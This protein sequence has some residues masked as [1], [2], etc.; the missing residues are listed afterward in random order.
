MVIEL[1]S[2]NFFKTNLFDH[3]VGMAMDPVP[4]IRMRLCPMLPLLK[5]LIKFP[6]DRAL[7]QSLE[8]CIRKVLVN[9]KDKDVIEAI[10]QVVYSVTGFIHIGQVHQQHCIRMFM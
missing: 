4:N 9:E 5:G 7:L 2:R 6:T 8:Q 3:L 1:F 10:D